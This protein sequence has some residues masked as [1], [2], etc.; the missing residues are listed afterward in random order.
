VVTVTGPGNQTTIAGTKVSV[1]VAA[2]DSEGAPLTYTA[3][4]LP[5]GLSISASGLITGT[6]STTGTW[7]PKVAASN[8]A[9]GFGSASLTWT[10]DPNTVTLTNPGRK[11]SKLG[12]RVSLRI[13]G[14][15]SP[16][17]PLTYSASGLPPG[18]SIS[19]SGLISGKPKI[20]ETKS[21]T[22]TATDSTGGSGKVTFTWSIVTTAALSRASLTGVTAGKPKLAFSVAAVG[23]SPKLEKIAIRL[24][25]GL[26]FSTRARKLVKGIALTKGVRFQAAVRHGVLTIELRREE[27]RLKVTISSTELSVTKNLRGQVAGGVV[28]TVSL[29]VEAT[30]SA[31]RTVALGLAL[32]V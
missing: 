28:K 15:D 26:S 24:P 17:T 30:N 27:A 12:A 25:K 18:L 21:T 11:T 13:T 4:G 6:P 31:R 19:A 32:G 2:S 8:A 29:T 9:G 1:Q 23:R 3:T 7:T 22:I 16:G 5:P 20:A 14:S 10:V